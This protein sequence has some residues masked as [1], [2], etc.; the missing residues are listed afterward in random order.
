MVYLK[1]DF[2]SCMHIPK[3]YTKQPLQILYHHIYLYLKKALQ[4]KKNY[5]KIPRYD[6]KVFS[7]KQ[8]QRYQ[9]TV[10]TGPQKV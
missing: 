4:I 2:K 9:F 5:I 7:L 10:L 8:P 6:F 3:D 1:P